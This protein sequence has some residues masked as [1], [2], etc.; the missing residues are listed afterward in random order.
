[1][2]LQNEAPESTD[3]V[4]VEVGLILTLLALLSLTICAQKGKLGAGLLGLLTLF[5]VLGVAIRIAKPNS[6][7]AKRH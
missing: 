7:W 1:M 6:T 5:G 2:V 4:S 3:V